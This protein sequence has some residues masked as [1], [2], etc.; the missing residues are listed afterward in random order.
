[1]TLER[2]TAMDRRESCTHLETNGKTETLAEEEGWLQLLG[3]GTTFLKMRRS[4]R[5]R[6][7]SGVLSVGPAL[8]PLT[9]GQ[10]L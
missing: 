6:A 8:S 5:F 2:I 7:D 1:M 3:L 4:V 9:K 10:P